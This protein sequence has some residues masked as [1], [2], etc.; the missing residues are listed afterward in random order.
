MREKIVDKGG[1]FFSENEGFYLFSQL[2]G[3]HNEDA[4]K[5][6]S[7]RQLCKECVDVSE[8]NKLLTHQDTDCSIIFNDKTHSYSQL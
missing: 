3:N 8:K 7:L 2:E 4:E 5:L 6:L 1:F